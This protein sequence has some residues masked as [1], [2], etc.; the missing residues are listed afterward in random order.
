MV[1]NNN[2]VVNHQE[3]VSAFNARFMNVIA[4]FCTHTNIIT[5]LKLYDVKQIHHYIC[6]KLVFQK[7]KRYIRELTNNASTVSGPQPDSK[8]K[9]T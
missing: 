9:K 2:E 1:T 5:V 8:K 4:N 7:K 6:E 3:I